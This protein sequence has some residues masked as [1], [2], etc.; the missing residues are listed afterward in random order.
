MRAVL[1]GVLAVGLGS[2]AVWAASGPARAVAPSAETGADIAARWCA[3]CHVVSPSGAGTDAAPSFA[4]IAGRRDPAD[5][6]LFLSQPHA[7]AM[8]GFDLTAREIEDVVAYI[9][10]LGQRST[11]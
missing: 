3:G 6:R 7:P 2:V 5:L 10:T 8:R 11:P 1:G 9:G 4:A